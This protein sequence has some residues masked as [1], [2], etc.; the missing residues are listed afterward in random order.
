[1][2]FKRM[3]IGNFNYGQEFFEK[4]LI[5]LKDKYGKITNFDFYDNEFL[6][7]IRDDDHD[8]YNNIKYFLLC[9]CLCHT[10]LT[11]KNNKNELIYQGSSPD[12]I[13]LINAARYFQYIF[14]KREIGNKIVLEVFG[15]KEEYLVN[16]YLE[17]SSE[18]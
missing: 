9:I 14:L 3:S 8:N 15:V 11:E 17:Y 13:S 4:N 7:H 10:I 6:D 12:E 2:M 5:K 1:M 16:F 18:R